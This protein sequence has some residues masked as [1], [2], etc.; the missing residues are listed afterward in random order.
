MANFR[1]V[2]NEANRVGNPRKYQIASNTAIEKGEVVKLTNGL[3]VAIGD[4]DQDDPYLG[5]SAVAHDGAT[6]DGVQTATEIL[7]YDDP[8]DVFAVYPTAYLTATGGSTTTFVDSSIL[9]ATDDI[10]NGGAIKI[11]TCAADSTLVGRVIKISDFTGSGGTITL[12][13]TLPAAFAAGDTAYLCPGPRAIGQFGWDLNS[14]GDDIN[15]ESS[16]GESLVFVGSDIINFEVYF[17]LRL[18]LKGNNVNA[19]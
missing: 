3:V 10:F 12:A 19:L 7:I 14:D 9:P 2:R 4:A 18:H 1:F 17:K 15:W 13:E 5:I 16:G 8:N 6:A 11:R